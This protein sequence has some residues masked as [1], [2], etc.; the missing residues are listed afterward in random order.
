MMVYL[1]MQLDKTGIEPSPIDVFRKFHV[2]K[3]KEGEPEYWTSE[4][5]K[6]LH[7]CFIM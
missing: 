6:D 7:V 5:A 3:S 1:N 4:K 2:S